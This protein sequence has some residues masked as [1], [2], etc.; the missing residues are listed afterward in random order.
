MNPPVFFDHIEA[1]VQDVPRYC[2]FL[3]KLFQSG[4]YKVISDTG[5]SM[6][7]SNEGLCIEI[8]KR[9]D[10]QPPLPSGFCNP[11]LR[12]NGAKDFIQKSL[13][14]P[15]TKIVENPDGSVFFFQDHEGVTWHIKDYL[16]RDKFVNW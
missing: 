5:T 8:K 9:K 13:R 1:H 4:R 11:C 12:M 2:E 14:L 15:I 10:D 16:A 7:V 6:F 3:L